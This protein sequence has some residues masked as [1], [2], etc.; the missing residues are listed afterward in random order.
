MRAG[1]SSLVPG[2]RLGRYE[3]LEELGRGGMGIVFKARDPAIGRL[4]AIKTLHLEMLAA[5]GYGAEA[6]ARF[7]REAQAIGQLAHP[8]I[9]TLFDAQQE[10][11]VL[12]LVM[13]LVSGRSL[14]VLLRSGAL[15]PAEQVSAIGIEVCEALE[16]AHARGVIHRDIKPDNI[17][18]QESGA[19]KVAD[20]GV[21]Y[22]AM[23]A[24][25]RP[26]ES[27]GTPSYMSPE[28]IAG[29]SVDA[30]SDIFSL[31][32]VLY[33]LGCTQKAFP[34]ETISTVIYRI[35]HAEPTPLH[36]VN[37]AFPP[38][39]DAAIRKAMAKDPGARY[40]SARE[41]LEALARAAALMASPAAQ[42]IPSAPSLEAAPGP[43]SGRRWLPLGATA[44]AG[45]VVLAG[46]VWLSRP[47]SPREAEPPAP[48]GPP[49]LAG[50][51]PAPA[52]APAPPASGTPSA[53][54]VAFARDIQGM[55]PLEEGETFY[56]DDRQVVLWIR[57][58]NV[59]GA[60]RVVVRW[61]NAEGLLVH[62]SRPEPFD[63]PADVW[64]TW[65]VLP[66]Q[67]GMVAKS[68]GR[69]RAEVQLDGKPVVAAHFSVL[70]QRRRLPAS[71]A[72]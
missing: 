25:T 64:T 43:R 26:G 53:L 35:L 1:A 71:R 4:V 36:E 62:A 9:V 46:L 8:H 16:H 7:A 66:F 63:S 31:G 19:V 22:L 6:R 44:A 37:P 20:F 72:E 30:R 65:A 40:A 60:H 12:Y 57:W 28:Q 33:E 27:L 10:G 68:P 58:A 2:G 41:F 3:L 34:G 50:R 59:R 49:A 13:E 45:A 47:P 48:A 5:T 32:A 61:F 15:F 21:A 23:S 17:L 24:L 54:R 56:R 38:L 70:N 69:W 11:E 67:R 42:A 18:L 39:L 29:K 52:P 55:L 51:A 14:E